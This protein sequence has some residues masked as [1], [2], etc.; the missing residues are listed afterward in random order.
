MKNHIWALGLLAVSSMLYAQ[1]ATHF[2]KED[3]LA[4]FR[5]YNPGVL[6][7]A[8]T[9]RAYGDI[10]NQLATSYSM[11]RNEENRY[12]LIALVK[13]FDNSLILEALRQDYV[14]Q[15]NLYTMSG[16]PAPEGLEKNTL[17]QLNRLVTDIFNNTIDVKQIQIKDYKQQIKQVRRDS[18][19]AADQK[20]QQIKQLKEK[21]NQVKQEMRVL[22][23]DSKQKIQD[24]TVVYFADI[25]AQYLASLP[26]QLRAEQS[27]SR[28]VKANHQKPVA[29]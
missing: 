23:K 19:L 12:M 2:N 22:K 15:M 1:E 28:D 29:E 10:V 8:A 21:I 11:E 14:Q 5:T 6:Q 18:T 25:R 20:Q 3:L 13:N 24:T 4:A 16:S 9:N 7:R 26:Q 27:S 17:S